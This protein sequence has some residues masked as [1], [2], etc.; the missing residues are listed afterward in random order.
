MKFLSLSGAPRVPALLT[1]LCAFLTVLAGVEAL[2]R[3]SWFWTLHQPLSVEQRFIEP[4]LRRA[5]NP[6]I[7]FMGNS[8]LRVGISPKIV[9]EHMGLP[10]TEVANL[11]FDGGEPH[12]LLQVY[13]AYRTRLKKANVLVIGV[14]AKMF[15]QGLATIA[16]TSPSDRQNAS[17]T[18]RL[19]VP[20]WA[21]KIDLSVGWF[22]KT[23]DTR[24]ILSQYLKDVIKAKRGP[25]F[26]DLDRLMMGPQPSTNPS[27]SD[28]LGRTDHLDYILDDREIQ[29][30]QE[31][32][33]LAQEDGIKV[34]LV[35]A[36]LGPVYRSMVQ[37]RFHRED[38]NWRRQIEE[39][40][41]LNVARVPLTNRR[42]VAWRD[43]FVDAGH[44]NHLGAQAYSDDIGVW[45]IAE[46]SEW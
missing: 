11:A 34:M 10:T 43:C 44:L 29:A 30:L 38:A 5:P 13:Q 36:P 31:L 45:L 3:T 2:V 17:L 33:S 37:E 28:S 41:G 32:V 23:W 40:T 22:W 19:G 14:E 6:H 46:V 39:N 8:R 26:D 7:V 4:A 12:E 16:E 24:A 9:S 27:D 35:D 20:S 25:Y 1:W 18:D 42:C 21:D 15:K